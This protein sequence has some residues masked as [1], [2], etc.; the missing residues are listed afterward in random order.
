MR[1]T[2]VLVV[3]PRTGKIIK[4]GLCERGEKLVQNGVL[5]F[6]FRFSQWSVLHFVFRFSQWSEIA[7]ESENLSRGKT[8]FSERGLA[9]KGLNA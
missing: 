3:A 7:L 5:H 2:L 8:D 1:V 9:L 4:N 6:V